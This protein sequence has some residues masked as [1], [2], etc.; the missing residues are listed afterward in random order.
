M[1]MQQQDPDDARRDRDRDQRPRDENTKHRSPRT[2]HASVSSMLD[3]TRR[4]DTRAVCLSVISA[5]MVT[6]TASQKHP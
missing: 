3:L 5:P 6:A 2:A 4:R 1:R